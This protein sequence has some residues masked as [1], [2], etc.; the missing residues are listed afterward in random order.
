MIHP[1]LPPRRNTRGTRFLLAVVVAVLGILSFLLG[2]TPYA[3]YS[4]TVDTSTKTS[5]SFF[6]N[7]GEA[8]AA[9]L[10]LLLAAGLI[11]G[12]GLMPRQA[13]NESIV[14]GLSLAGFASLLFAMIGLTDDMEAGVGLIL[15]MV[16][17]FMQSAVAVVALLIS[18]SVVKLG[19]PA[20]VPERS[21]FYSN[22]QGHLPP[23]PP[24]NYPMRPP[25]ERTRYLGQDRNNPL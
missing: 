8:G 16:S 2:F 17:S 20:Y 3:K 12:F 13:T 22:Q 18:A 21:G 4:L 11:A 14:A 6:E 19:S 9:A 5:V 24:G 15:A 23:Q 25:S 7:S 10:A 1:N